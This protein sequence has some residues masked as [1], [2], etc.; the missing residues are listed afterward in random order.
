MAEKEGN[1]AAESGDEFDLIS[2]ACNMREADDNDTAMGERPSGT[3]RAQCSIGGKSDTNAVSVKPKVKP[4]HDESSLKGHTSG[5]TSSK[6]RKVKKASNIQKER[7]VVD[8]TTKRL[9][10]LGK[11]IG[12]FY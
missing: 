10:K 12:R 6:K 4:R 8:D 5:E 3:K 2:Q 7:K 11:F 1:S 9:D